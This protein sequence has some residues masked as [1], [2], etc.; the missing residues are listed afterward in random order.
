MKIV[1]H[2]FQLLM[3]LLAFN[4]LSMAGDSARKIDRDANGALSQFYHEVKGSEK[5]LQNAKAYLV[6]PD[7]NEGGF[8]IGGRYGEGVLRIG[9]RTK[10]FYSITSLS[11]GFQA[12]VKNYA[13]VIAVVSDRALDRLLRDDHKWET[14][15]A[16]NITIAD[17]NSDEEN[18]DV[19][20]GSGLVG[21]VF[22][23]TGMMGSISLER[24]QFE[25]INPHGSRN[26][27]AY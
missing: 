9:G 7:V 14:E 26:S 16:T 19:G 20:V 17:W 10:A 22:D 2:T 5:Y 4:T 1:K 13:L 25:R 11:A 8:F 24:N 6:F 15:I 27:P 18:D 12:G 21:F 23:S 3:I